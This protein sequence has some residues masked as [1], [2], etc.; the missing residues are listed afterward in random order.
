MHADSGNVVF[1]KRRQKAAKAR[2][3]AQG[4]HFALVPANVH[5]RV[6]RHDEVCAEVNG[7]LHHA[8]GNIK[9]DKN[10][11]DLPLGIADKMADIVPVHR[12]LARRPGKK[13]LL[14]FTYGCHAPTPLSAS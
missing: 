5:H 7:L 12:A 8:L 4:L 13:T 6:V 1:H 9:C 14:H 3:A 2:I 10:A 11:L